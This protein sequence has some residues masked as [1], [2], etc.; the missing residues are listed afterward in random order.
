MKRKKYDYYYNKLKIRFPFILHKITIPKKKSVITTLRLL[1]ADVQGQFF[2]EK[3]FSI[4]V[5][6]FLSTRNFPQK[7]NY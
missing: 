7:I 4:Q 3:Q 1:Y 2:Q 5:S 6:D